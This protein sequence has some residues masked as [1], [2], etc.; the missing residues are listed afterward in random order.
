MSETDDQVRLL[1][2]EIETLQIRL[3]E[4]EETVASLCI[5]S[6]DTILISTVEGEKV[7]TLKTA[8]K[9]YRLF[10][11]NMNQGAVLL[12]EDDTILYCNQAFAGMV[13]DVAEVVVGKK[14]QAYIPQA[15]HG[16]FHTVLAKSTL[17]RATQEQNFHLQTREG[18]TLA[19]RFS[20][21][22]IHQDDFKATCIVVI[23]LSH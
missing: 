23:G 21:S 20:F 11:E 18:S 6:A 19:A 14:V 16:E 3:Q 4:L 22:Q 10:V 17:E 2:L 13:K 15:V 1:K 8:E 7:F 12:S 5:G 9:P